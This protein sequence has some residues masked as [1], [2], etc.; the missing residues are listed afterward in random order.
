[1]FTAHRVTEF[2]Q[3]ACVYYIRLDEFVHEFDIGVEH[4]LDDRDTPETPYI[5]VMDDHRKPVG[6]CR[7]RYLEDCTGKIERVSVLKQFRGTGAGR[8]AIAA[9]E[10][11][12]REN[13]VTK[14]V[15][16]SRD[17]AVGFYEKLG[18]V[19]D[20]ASLEQ[21]EGLFGTVNTYKTLEA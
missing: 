18:Y 6:T 3:R 19:T 16:N 2:W 21:G 12:L 11:W 20:W 1:M 9:A 7:L 10:D 4:E 13:G 8:V 17:T 5:L 14:I 15:I